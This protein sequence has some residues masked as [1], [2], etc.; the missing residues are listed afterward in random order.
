L[1]PL[2]LLVLLAGLLFHVAA[3][4]VTAHESPTRE[5]VTSND[6][7]VI[8]ILFTAYDIIKKRG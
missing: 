4:P 3:L 8:A 1:T 5:A 2:A 6:L 7:V